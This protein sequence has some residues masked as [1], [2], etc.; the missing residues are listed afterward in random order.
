M[1]KRI[2]YV[3]M[4]ILIISTPI[5]ALEW[6]AVNYSNPE[7]IKESGLTIDE[8]ND[9]SQSEW[10]ELLSDKKRVNFAFSVTNSEGNDV[11]NEVNPD[12]KFDI[13]GLNGSQTV[14]FKTLEL[15][16]EKEK[17]VEIPK[18]KEYN[19]I[20]YVD[21]IN[22]NDT[23]G[24]GSINNPYQ[25]FYYAYDNHVSSGDLLYLKEGVYNLE[26]RHQDGISSRNEQFYL[27]KDNVD[28]FGEPGKVNITNKNTPSVNWNHFVGSNVSNV[29]VFNLIFKSQDAGWKAVAGDGSGFDTSRS[30]NFYN[31]V[32]D[33]PNVDILLYQ[34]GATSK[35][36]NCIFNTKNKNVYT[37]QGGSTFI[38]SAFTNSNDIY[39]NYNNTGYT[40]ENI[41]NSVT[42]GSNYNITSSGWQNA[43]TG[44]NPDGSKAHIGVYGGKFAW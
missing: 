2:F 4:I 12:L 44:E 10:L 35:F 39:Y 3:L 27:N 34:N 1:Y 16:N 43:G 36:Y 29:N 25:S 5:Y 11:T 38:N 42:L 30:I 22:G 7:L 15:D 26:Y 18:L 31:S 14:T 37:N 23:T 28:V 40:A 19:N 41:L 9:L 32:F 8:F 6:K 20:V 17:K 21:A 24:D 13:D 33:L